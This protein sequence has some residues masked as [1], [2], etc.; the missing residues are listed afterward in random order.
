[1]RYLKKNNK[2]AK[3]EKQKYLIDLFFDNDEKYDCLCDVPEEERV[4]E[5][6]CKE[7]ANSMMLECPSE[8]KR[9]TLI[10][11]FKNQKHI[12]YAVGELK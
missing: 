4:Y 5:E 2:M 11:K 1:M 7:H 6:D 3:E 10:K 12:L 9:D 8:E